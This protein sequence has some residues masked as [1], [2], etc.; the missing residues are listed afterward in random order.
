MADAPAAPSKPAR[1]RKAASEKKPAT[2]VADFRGIK[3]KLPDEL[4]GALYFDLGSLASVE[5]EASSAAA[6]IRLLNTLLGDDGVQKVRAKIIDDGVSFDEVENV[7][8]GLFET[9]TDAY[10]TTPGNSAASPES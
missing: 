1:A 5:D 4:P 3:L 7:L 6:Q 2:K 10:H 9:V 8:M